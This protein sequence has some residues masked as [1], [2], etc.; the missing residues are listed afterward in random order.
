MCTRLVSRSRALRCSLLPAVMLCLVYRVL[1]Q[2]ADT[3]SIIGQVRIVRGSFP[4][5]RIAISIA[6][7]GFP[8]GTTYTDDEGR[9]S[10]LLLPPNRYHINVSDP[11]YLPVTVEAEI[12]GGMTANL[13]VEI[14]QRHAGSQSDPRTIT[15]GNPYLTDQEEYERHFPTKA[16]KEFRAGVKA[17]AKNNSEIAV[18]HYRKALELAPDFLPARNNLGSDYMNQGNLQAA[19]NEFEAVVKVA[20]ADAAAYLN[21]G[22]V[23]LLTKRYHLAERAIQQGLEKQP[24]SSFG[25]F[26]EG[27]LLQRQGRANE[28]EAALRRA[29]QLDA[30]VFKARL[31]LVNLYLQQGR[32]SEAESEL[33]EFLKSAP[34]DPLAPKAREVLAKL[35]SETPVR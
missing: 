31:A 27:S 23:Y 10:F 8:I 30:G 26:L 9:F 14:T 5:H 15:G 17:D 2:A 19:E 11:D 24:N 13:L 6:T 32:K 22:N 35:K 29:L 18:A 12:K 20:P 1:G 33:S 7:R 3:G 28:A 25:L 34:N 4:S 21:L 16:I